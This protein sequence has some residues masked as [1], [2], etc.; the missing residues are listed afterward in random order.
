M[1]EVDKYF[2]EESRCT[3][4]PSNPEIIKKS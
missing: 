2:L 4:A 3:K 1:R